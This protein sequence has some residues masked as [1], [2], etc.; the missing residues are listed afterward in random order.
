MA[1]FATG[2]SRSWALGRR[3]YGIFRTGGRSWCNTWFSL[4]K[5]WV[6]R[7]LSCFW[8]MSEKE[9]SSGK[10]PRRLSYRGTVGDLELEIE[11]LEMSRVCW[12]CAWCRL[13]RRFHY[14]STYIGYLVLCCFAF[15]HS[16]IIFGE[17]LIDNRY[18]H[19]GIH[20]RHAGSPGYI[21][22]VPDHKATYLACRITRIHSW[23]AG[24]PGYIAGMPDHHG[25]IA[26]MSDYQD[27]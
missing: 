12:L 17:M 5:I 23:H 10:K 9:T 7:L 25:Y 1:V 3:E 11:V 16:G 6:K 19:H 27:T 20:S 21:I 24:S 2:N 26:G 14:N 8:Q 18:G 15:V 4:A 22:G 13:Y